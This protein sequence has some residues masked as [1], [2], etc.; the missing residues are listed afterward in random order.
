MIT[1]TRRRRRIYFLHNAIHKDFCKYVD[2]MVLPISENY[3]KTDE[4][5]HIGHY[6]G[7]FL[8]TKFFSLFLN[9]GYEASAPRSSG[10]R[11]YSPAAW[12]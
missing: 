1:T 2:R 10:R 12:L 11:L 9:T 4:S 3:Y 5:L 8:F 7:I 6:I